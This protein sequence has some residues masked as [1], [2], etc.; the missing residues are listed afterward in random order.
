M[1]KVEAGLA[2]PCRALALAWL[3]GGKQGKLT[4]VWMWHDRTID[5]DD[6]V[7]VLQMNC[8]LHKGERDLNFSSLWQNEEQG[9]MASMIYL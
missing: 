9:E 8:R 4:G 7:R 2:T 3:L 1:L 5:V 6:S